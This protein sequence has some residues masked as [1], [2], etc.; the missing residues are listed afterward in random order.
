MISD[1]TLGVDDVLITSAIPEPGTYLLM[2][3]GVA[4]LMLR[5][6]L[7]LLFARL[8]LLLPLLKHFHDLAV[9]IL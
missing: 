9:S 5:R 4:G 6:Q 8:G 3:L 1:S 2:G 7:L